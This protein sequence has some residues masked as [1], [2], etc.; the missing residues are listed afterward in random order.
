M[1]AEG[2]TWAVLQT[3]DFRIPA[4]KTYL[5]LGFEPLIVHENQPKRWK[6]VFSAIGRP[7]LIDKIF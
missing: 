2:R 3:D 1:A 6:D 4:V 5:K 7:E